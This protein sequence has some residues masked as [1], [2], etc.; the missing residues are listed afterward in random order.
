MTS[1]A[2]TV[3][4][5]LSN[6]GD[7]CVAAYGSIASAPLPVPALVIQPAGTLAITDC[8]DLLIVRA[9]S[10]ATA[11]QGSPQQCA[12]VMVANLEVT[13][14][15]CIPN[16]TDWGAAA[17][18]AEL[19]AAALALADDVSTLWY[20]LAGACRAG[21]LW[22]GF[23]DLGCADTSFGPARPGGSGG[24]GFWTFPVSV[25]VTANLT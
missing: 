20:G 24:V 8:G 4:T 9:A 5:L 12:L 11:F 19:T 1:V 18:Q 23:A 13:V 15:R 2:K 17:S 3:S 16:L 14:T 25:N 6:L 21:T 22:A 10:I 7:A